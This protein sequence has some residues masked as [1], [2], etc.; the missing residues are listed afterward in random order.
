[1]GEKIRCMQIGTVEA[2]REQ[3][4]RVYSPDGLSPTLTTFG[5]GYRNKGRYKRSD[6]KGI[7]DR[8]S[9]RQY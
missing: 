3:N 8:R 7:R 1:M 2:S 4:G 5:G 6:S 9:R